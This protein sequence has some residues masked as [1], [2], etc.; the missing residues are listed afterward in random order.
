[1][2]DPGA[3]CLM[4]EPMRSTAIVLNTNSASTQTKDTSNAVTRQCPNLMKELE[5]REA[6]KVAEGPFMWKVNRTGPRELDCGDE[7]R[8]RQASD[9]YKNAYLTA[10]PQLPATASGG[11]LDHYPDHYPGKEGTGGVLFLTT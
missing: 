2:A 10:R 7:P 4:M 3:R 8:H 1:M 9:S 11:S 6:S 5:M